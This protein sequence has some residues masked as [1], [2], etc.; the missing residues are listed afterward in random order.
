MHFKDFLLNEE[1]AYLGH[2]VSD[3][4]TGVHDLE[5]DMPGMGVRHIMKVAEDIVSQIRKIIHGQW[6][7]RHTKDLKD[8]QKIGVALMKAIDEKGDL[9]TLI[10]TISQSLETISGRLGIKT[11]D[12]QPPEESGGETG[13]NGQD[14]SMQLTANGPPPP[15]PG[16]PPGQQPPTPMGLGAAPQLGGPPMAGLP[17]LPPQ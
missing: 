11:N 15:N 12:I 6:S 9:K 2:R 14:M 8:L 16:Q 4:L 7:P 17:G 13:Q 3:V 1:K 5:E 10:P